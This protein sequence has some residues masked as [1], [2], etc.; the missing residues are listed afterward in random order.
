MLFF[1]VEH[2][3]TPLRETTMSKKRDFMSRYKTY[4]VAKH[5]YGSVAEWSRQ[6]DERM[7]FDEAT[8][9]V[10]KNDP[11]TILGLLHLPTMAELK[12]VFRKLILIHHPDRGGSEEQAKLIIAAY[13]VLTDR[14]ER[15]SK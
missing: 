8:K 14:I 11:L 13:T 15:L 6:F 9:R 4:D 2:A 3:K 1:S 12:L 5:G 7:G 10:D